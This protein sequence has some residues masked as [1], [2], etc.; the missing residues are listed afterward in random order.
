MPSK[1]EIR[2]RLAGRALMATYTVEVEQF[3]KSNKS[4]EVEAD[5]YHFNKVDEH[6]I[7]VG[8]KK[9]GEFVESIKA[10]NILRI[11]KNE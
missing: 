6:L 3:E 7:F 11:S 9:Q 2:V 4:I 1:Q 8:F 5:S 10:S